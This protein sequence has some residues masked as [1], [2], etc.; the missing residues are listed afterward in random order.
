MAALDHPLKAEI[1]AIRRLILDAG[2]GVEESVKWNAPSF[3]LGSGGEHFATFHLRRPGVVQLVLHSGAKKRAAPLAMDIPDPQ[4]LLVW[5]A[6]DRAIVGFTDTEDLAA[7]RPAFEAVV[8][9]WA[10]ALRKAV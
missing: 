9:A 6:K 8:L 2:G 5:Q 4:G 1:E 7:K 3:S 10:E